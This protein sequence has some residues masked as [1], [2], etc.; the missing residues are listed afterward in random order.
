[1]GSLLRCLPLNPFSIYKLSLSCSIFPFL[2]EK[3]VLFS[4]ISFCHLQIVSQSVSHL[5]L[6]LISCFLS[7]HSTVLLSVIPCLPQL[8]F[9]F[10]IFCFPP[11]PSWH[12]SCNRCPSAS[13][14]PLCTVTMSQNYLTCYSVQVFLS[15]YLLLALARNTLNVCCSFGSK[16]KPPQHPPILSLCELPG[17]RAAGPG[18]GRSPIPPQHKEGPSWPWT[19]RRRGGVKDQLAPFRLLTSAQ[20]LFPTALQ[21]PAIIYLRSFRGSA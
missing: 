1:M 18:G 9:C 19:L 15:S 16:A 20:L 11:S 7:S 8:F 12:P 17:E 3:H 10:F 13:S 6:P 2:L 5:Q 21:I 14:F 4:I